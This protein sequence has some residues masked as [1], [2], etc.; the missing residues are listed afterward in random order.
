MFQDDENTRRNKTLGFA[1]A[2]AGGLAL[3][4]I[5]VGEA[6]QMVADA[7]SPG[8]AQVVMAE[9]KK[10]IFNAID[11]ATTGAVKGQ[12]VVLAPCQR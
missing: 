4:C 6:A 8:G 9:P 1:A 5:L 10:P 12:T 7:S 2:W 11:F 3:F